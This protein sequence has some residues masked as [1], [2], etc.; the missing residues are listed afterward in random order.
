MNVRP[1]PEFLG[2]AIIDAIHEGQIKTYGGLHGLRNEKGLKS[3][4]AAAQNVYYFGDG[5]I[6]DIEAANAYN[7]AESQSLF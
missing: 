5:D 3:A 6:Y 1:E 2:R 7:L 4:I